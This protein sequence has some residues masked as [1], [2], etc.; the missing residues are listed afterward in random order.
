VKNLLS[1]LILVRI[2]VL[3]F[4]FCNLV[5]T[6]NLLSV[7]D[8]GKFTFTVSI[9]QFFI[10][11]LN[12]GLP[13]VLA[14][15]IP[16]SKF[17][18]TRPI[19]FKQ[20]IF[21]FIFFTF[22]FFSNFLLKIFNPVLLLIIFNNVFLW[23]NSFA[24]NINRYKKSTLILGQFR[25]GGG[26]LINFLFFLFIFLSFLFNVSLSLEDIFIY[27]FF[28]SLITL[29]ISEIYISKMFKN[30]HSK[31]SIKEILKI[32]I[33]IGIQKSIDP[34]QE[35]VFFIMCNYFLSDI[36]LGIFF[37]A[38][39]IG[40]LTW[41]LFT[42]VLDVNFFPLIANNIVNNNSNKLNQLLQQRTAIHF[43]ST[44]SLGLI[45]FLVYDFIVPI[46]F[47]NY[48]VAKQLILVFII[49]LS[50]L[51][52]FVDSIF[53]GEVMQLSTKIIIFRM[54]SLS[55]YLIPFLFT[56]HNMYLYPFLFSFQF[57]LI[58]LLTSKEINQKIKIDYFVKFYKNNNIKF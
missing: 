34:I 48:L 46:F 51:S 7:Q 11:L 18:D 23:I 31:V 28:S 53:S 21:L 55:F 37:F 6:S 10:F 39:R 41:N 50:I 8:F 52:F 42:T 35:A 38:Y 45:V 5:I 40:T 57:L 16:K 30:N 13:N 58:R 26:V 32:S 20:K 54:I 47:P 43:L 27:L 44:I 14:I 56:N 12:F 36:E 25:P 1:S 15:L 3:F 49:A 9:L 33:P 2:S 24:L 4:G 19:L 22:I 29:F 17:K